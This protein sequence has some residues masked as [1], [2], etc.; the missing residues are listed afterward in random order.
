V[1]ALFATK[2]GV[3]KSMIAVNLALGLASQYQ[4]KTLLVDADLWFGDVG[5]LL[6]LPTNNSLFEAYDSEGELDQTRL[7]KVL[8]PHPSGASLLLRPADPSMAERIDPAAVLH[9]L[10]TYRAFFDYIIVDTH[11]TFN[12]MNLQILEVADRILLVTTPEISAIHNTARFLAIADA[13]GYTKKISLILNRANSGIQL[14]ALEQQL[15]TQISATVVSSGKIVVDASNRGN[16]LIMDEDQ[17]H[18]TVTQNLRGIAESVAGKPWPGL[19]HPG[20]P[21]S[22]SLRNLLPFMSKKQD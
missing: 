6:N 4:E 10:A 13:L 19:T 5:V 8:T 20:R 17:A 12:E 21:K 18:E 2:G 16:P 9:A 11:S 7:L 22:R 14:A 15:G 1:V 3:G